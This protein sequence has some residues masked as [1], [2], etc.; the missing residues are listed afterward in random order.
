MRVE[1][2]LLAS[3]ATSS[4]SCDALPFLL[5]MIRTTFQHFSGAKFME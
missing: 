2:D 5:V 4:A 1:D 3:D